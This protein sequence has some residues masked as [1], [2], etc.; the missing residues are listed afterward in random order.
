MKLSSSITTPGES[1]ASRPADE[2][3]RLQF[4]I[5]LR[6]VASILIL[7]HHF[8]LYPPLREWAAPLIGGA[9]DWF[10]L[11]A[12]ATQV[13]F[14]VGGYVMARSMSRKNWSVRYMCMFIAQ[15]YFRL[16]IPYLGAIALAIS[17]YAVARGWL[18]DSVL[19]EAV[20]FPQLL[21]HVFFLQDILGYEQLSAGL[22][23]VCS[24][25]QKA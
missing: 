4:V 9:L 12:R 14:V 7:W 25:R 2:G 16:G 20:S 8:A 5:A 22:W 21:A 15:R 11:N 1:T 10:E 18:P 19:G 3:Q 6:A 23:F 24:N 17:A 13:F